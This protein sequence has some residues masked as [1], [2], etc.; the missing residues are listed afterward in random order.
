MAGWI[1]LYGRKTAD[2]AGEKYESELSNIKVN[3]NEIQF[4][5]NLN[6][7]GMPLVITYKG[8]IVGDEI[9][10]TRNVGDFPAEEFIIKRVQS[11][12]TIKK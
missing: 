8:K 12:D 3:G 9:H 11:K 7:Q 1:R 5:E 10:L 6:Y 4:I 2:I